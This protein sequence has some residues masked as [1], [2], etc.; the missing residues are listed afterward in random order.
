M[1]DHCSNTLSGLEQRILRELKSLNEELLERVTLDNTSGLDA[2]IKLKSGER[3]ILRAEEIER[4]KKKI[5]EHLRSK[6]LLP[7]E[8]SI[9]VGENEIKYIVNGDIWQ[10]RMVRYL[11]SGELEWKPPVEIGKEE[12]SELI[13]EFPSLVRLKLVVG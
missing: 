9:I 4:L 3:L 2:E 5:P 8:I 10:V 11:H 6:I 7:I 12:L 1:E 13:R